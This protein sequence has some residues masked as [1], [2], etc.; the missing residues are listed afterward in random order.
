[1]SHSK[2]LVIAEAGINHGGKLITAIEMADAAKSV[3]ADIVKYQTYNTHKLLRPND[4]AYNELRALELQ[5]HE[6]VA[7]AKYCE[8]AKIEFLTTPGDLD[9]L[10]FAVEELGVKR[11]K[12]GSDD[13]TNV[14]LVEAAHDTGLPLILST[15]M[16]DVPEIVAATRFIWQFALLHCVSLYPCPVEKANLRSIPYLHDAFKCKVGYSDHTANS[17]VVLAAVAAGA[18][19]IEVHFMLDPLSVDEPQPIDAC[20]SFALSDLRDMIYQIR[21][22]ELYM[23]SYGKVPTSLER[24]KAPLLRKGSDGLRGLAA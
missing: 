18:Q 6:W 5:P 21:E 9:S 17:K 15:G 11:I 2:C 22:T 4:P 10:K 24:T 20:V 19:I 3:G 12:I 7:L 16:A 8:G 1:M 14:K 13:L 23:G